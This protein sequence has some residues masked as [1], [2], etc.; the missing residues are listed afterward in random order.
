MEYPKCTHSI[1]EALVENNYPKKYS[2]DFLN[3]FVGYFISQLNLNY[4]FTV[5]YFQI[6]INT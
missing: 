4:I 1:S 6:L 2:D 5:P 3:T